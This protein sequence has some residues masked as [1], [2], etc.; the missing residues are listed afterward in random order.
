[1]LRLTTPRSSFSW[2]LGLLSKA[3]GGIGSL[4]LLSWWVP[5]VGDLAQ[6]WDAC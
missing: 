3:G 1:M 4:G 2:V 6:Q 5:L